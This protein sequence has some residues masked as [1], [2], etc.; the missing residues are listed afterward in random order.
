MNHTVAQDKMPYHQTVQGY[1]SEILAQKQKENPRLSLRGLAKTIGIQPSFLSYI[2]NGKRNLSDEMIEQFAIKLQMSIEESQKFGLLARLER[3]KT[4]E[5]KE[6][7]LLEISK[8]NSTHNTSEMR[9][10]SVDLFKVIK[11]WHHNAILMLLEVSNY[12]WS[13]QSAAKLLG[14]ST[15]ELT[16]ALQR[17]ASLELITID[18]SGTPKKS[19]AR[20]KIQSNQMNAAIRQHQI[21]IANKSIESLTRYSPK[22]RHTGSDTYVLNNQDLKKARQ[23]IETATNELLKLSNQKGKN[24]NVYQLT[25]N[26]FPITTQLVNKGTTK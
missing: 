1:L 12:K 17:L 16:A 11:D 14:V 18:K 22:E 7:Y 15:V 4:P 25:F 19:A 5:L 10:L 24:K 21:Q 3:A 6:K 8:L 2:L 23:I 20:F 26:L 13:N 9:D